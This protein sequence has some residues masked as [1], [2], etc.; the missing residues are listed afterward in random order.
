MTREVRYRHT[1]LGNYPLMTLKITIL[2]ITF[3]KPCIHSQIH[4]LT[5]K[6]L[7]L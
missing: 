7:D 2:N 3:I 1:E 6:M 4:L 5:V